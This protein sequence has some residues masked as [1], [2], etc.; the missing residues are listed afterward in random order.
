MIF[1]LA[2]DVDRRLRQKQVDRRLAIPDHAMGGAIRR[3]VAGGEERIDLIVG[4]VDRAGRPCFLFALAAQL[5]SGLDKGL[6]LGL[7]NLGIHWSIS[8]FPGQGRPGN[9]TLWKIRRQIEL[10]PPT[11][12]RLLLPRPRG[13]ARCYQTSWASNQSSRTR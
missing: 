7:P 3:L 11:A 9:A 13:D 1:S 4:P 8:S 6:C 12:G 5:E 2:G 10:H